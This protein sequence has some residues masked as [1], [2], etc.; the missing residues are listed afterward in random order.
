M[1]RDWID[2]EYDRRFP[3]P[4]F[5]V[6]AARSWLG[7]CGDGG[8]TYF[9]AREDAAEHTRNMIAF[10]S[11]EADHVLARIGST[12][13]WEFRDPELEE[14]V[15]EGMAVGDLLFQYLICLRVRLRKLLDEPPPQAQTI[16][17]DPRDGDGWDQAVTVQGVR[18]PTGDEYFTSTHWELCRAD[19]LNGRCAECKRVTRTSLHH[20]PGSYGRL[21]CERPA[22]VLELCWD[23]HRGRH[24]RLRAA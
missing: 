4:H 16:A 2:D 6:R 1:K 11:C 7:Y 3:K 12:V 8:L 19:W 14:H 20:L 22:D 9:V 21:G 5:I 18:I 23:C 24:Q 10:V 13:P 17:I 15:R